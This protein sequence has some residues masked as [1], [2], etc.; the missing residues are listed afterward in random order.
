MGG[1]RDLIPN[2]AGMPHGEPQEVG[3]HLT[4]PLCG[5]GGRQPGPMAV[6]RCSEDGGSTWRL[7][8]LS[9]YQR[10]SHR[11]DGGA[12]AQ[13]S[14]TSE[15]VEAVASPARRSDTHLIRKGAVSVS[16]VESIAHHHTPATR[17]DLI[18]PPP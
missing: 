4:T 13:A 9:S 17:V 10:E 15:L 6:F 12:F 18:P 7:G 11:F 1:G 5:S 14:E 8:P 16:A 2:E 3:H